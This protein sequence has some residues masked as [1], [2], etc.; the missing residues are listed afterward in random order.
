M[1]NLHNENS[2]LFQS[3][4]ENIE[5]YFVLDLT[6]LASNGYFTDLVECLGDK[7]KFLCL[8]LPPKGLNVSN[9]DIIVSTPIGMF[10]SN[11]LRKLAFIVENL[12]ILEELKFF[13]FFDFFVSFSNK[14]PT[15]KEYFL[16]DLTK[17]YGF[18]SD[19][20]EPNI[21]IETIYQKNLD[22]LELSEALKPLIHGTI[23]KKINVMQGLLDHFTKNTNLLIDQVMDK[24]D[25]KSINLNKR[26]ETAQNKILLQ[27]AK[28]NRLNEIAWKIIKQF[29]EMKELDFSECETIFCIDKGEEQSE[30]K[31]N[32]EI[33][34]LQEALQIRKSHGGEGLPEDFESPEKLLQ[35]GRIEGGAPN[36][37]VDEIGLWEKEVIS[38]NLQNGIWDPIKNDA[39]LNHMHLRKIDWIQNDVVH[40]A[41]RELIQLRTSGKLKD[42]IKNKIEMNTENKI[43]DPISEY[44]INK[45]NRIDNIKAGN[46]NHSPTVFSYLGRPIPKLSHQEMP[47]IPKQKIIE[48]IQHS[49]NTEVSKNNKWKS[50]GR[51]IVKREMK[52]K[53]SEG[54]KI[55]PLNAKLS[56]FDISSKDVYNILL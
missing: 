21:L 54:L 13:K 8:T 47:Y 53:T 52:L 7:L 30:G 5:D 6:K 41:F 4:L 31:L 39:D 11:Q 36:N 9:E 19:L 26:L 28:V 33:L 51:P 50:Y 49:M 2:G 27:E 40:P 15:K 44:T 48:S 43:Y 35:F 37:I 25:E 20:Q 34:T 10:S 1:K 32:R 22:N 24:F 38:R 18:K 14:D 16:L 12:V 29:G 23:K 56:N 17:S 55:E 42:E 46:I 3:C 45:L